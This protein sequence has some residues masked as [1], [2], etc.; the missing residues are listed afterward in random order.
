MSGGDEP[1]AFGRGDVAENADCE[2]RSDCAGRGWVFG[3]KHLQSWL[4]GRG[5]RWRWSV[6]FAAAGLLMAVVGL[7]G[8]IVFLVAQRTQEI[9]VRMALGGTRLDILK[10]IVGKGM[11]LVALG[12]LVGLCVAFGVS[13]LLK[14]L[15]FSVGANDPISYLVVVLVL[16]GVALVATVIPA[17]GA[18]KVNPN[19]ALRYE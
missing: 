6:F 9:G 8:V 18:I 4:T 3:Q 5:L 11:G 19:V 17:I 7:Y 13:R 10:L 12:G 14:S 2:A 16:C 15:L 1:A